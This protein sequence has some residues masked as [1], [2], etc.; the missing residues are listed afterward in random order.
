MAT[1]PPKAEAEARGTEDIR[2]L[3]SMPRAVITIFLLF[4]AAGI[5]IVVWLFVNPPTAKQVALEL[6]R[7]P[8]VGTL[9]HD[10]VR[11]NPVDI[12]TDLQP[13]IPPC[14]QVRGLVVEGGQ[15]A[16]DRIYRTLG[17]VCK[18]F[19]SD[20]DRKEAVPDDV[21]KSI[22]A[23]ATARIRFALFKRTG[24]L[25]TT[26]LSQHRI[27]LAIALSRV[28][29]P[30]GPMAPLLIH[31]GYHLALGSPV[32]AAQEF[33]A[34]RVEYDACRLLFEPKVFTRGCDD[35][36]DIVAFG[37]ARAVELLVRAGYPQ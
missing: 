20:P 23:L 19:L 35:A 1:R 30:A 18:L 27:L 28:D 16:Q 12:P 2:F 13:F 24:D 17:P 6:R 5:G 8:P 37:E 29:A 33:A 36:R 7:S 21:L 32:T 10:V 3:Q 9:T 26:D 22:R 25:S 14:E 11:F 15:P 34:R 31:E 4:A